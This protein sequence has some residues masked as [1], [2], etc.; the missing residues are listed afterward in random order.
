M[1]DDDENTWVVD[2]ETWDMLMEMLDRPPRINE[3]LAE[4]MR[5]PSVFE[6]V[7]DPDLGEWFKAAWDKMREADHG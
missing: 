2:E 4:M 1:A 7:P 6:A 3:R 5:R